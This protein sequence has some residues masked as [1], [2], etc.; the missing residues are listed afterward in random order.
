MRLPRWFHL[1]GSPPFVYG[2]AGRLVPWLGAIAIVLLLVGA[3]WGLA[4]APPDRVQGEVY[5]I[6]FLHPQV[7]YISMMAYVVMA[8]S[9]GNRRAGFQIQI[10]NSFILC[11]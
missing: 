2:L 11:D 9:A 4:V 1:L 3:Y 7:A 8:V 6:L 5:R 10:L